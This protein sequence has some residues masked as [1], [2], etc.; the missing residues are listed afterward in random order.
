MFE[1]EQTRPDRVLSPRSSGLW[2][3]GA[4]R[5]VELTVGPDLCIVDVTRAA[6]KVWGLPLD[7]FQGMEFAACFTNPEAA[8]D[9]Y[10]LTVTN[11]FT[12]G[13][14]LE[15]KAPTGEFVYLQ[16]NAVRLEQGDALVLVTARNISERKSIPATLY[17]SEE[18]FRHTFEFAEIGLG[19]VDFQGRFIEVNRKL[20]ELLGLS[21]EELVGI[22]VRDVAEPTGEMT[23]LA[24][25]NMALEDNGNLAVYEKCYETNDQPTVWVEVSFRLVRTTTGKPVCVVASFRDI[26]E[27][28]YLQ[29]MLAEQ[30]SVDPLTKALTRKNFEE[31]SHIELSR[32]FRH[33]YKLSL[34]LIDMD[35][36]G[37]IND[38]YGTAAGDQILSECGNIICKCLRLTDLLGR[39]DGE[40]FSILLAET[41]PGGAKRVADRIR[42]TIEKFVFPDGVQITASIGVSGYRAGDSLSSLFNR[43]DNALFRAKQG[44][45]NRVVID[46]TDI[47]SD[48]INKAEKASFL[49]LHWKNSY[50]C[51]E[52]NI[53]DGRRKLFH[54]I[55]RMLATM[56]PEG[57]GTDLIPLISD[58][59]NE[60]HTHF[61]T[62]QAVLE[63]IRYAEIEAHKAM[64]LKLWDQVADLSARLKRT[65]ATAGDLMG[66]VV[67]ELIGRHILLEDRDFNPWLGMIQA[68]PQVAVPHVDGMPPQAETPAESGISA[69]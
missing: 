62:E 8:R 20:S 9:L 3:F 17:E 24:Y 37:L 38:K 35:Y 29:A 13:H 23:A 50:A 4:R 15:M 25:F 57:S 48:A 32:T 49:E 6:A 30:A 22:E 26:S 44:G 58:L 67:H 56:D 31:R 2:N 69:A 65:D 34:L 36:F 63:S 40:Q 5:E 59:L 53:D 27:H 10:N 43:A 55:N 64:H 14:I 21:K 16:C 19:M 39:W 18:T 68:T 45:R 54:I 7:Q 60:V 52:A 41:G 12:E 11:S 51:G 47:A 61:G 1:T 33:G 46:S 66:F 28:K 42:T